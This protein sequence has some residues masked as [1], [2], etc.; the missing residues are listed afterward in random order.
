[1]KQLSLFLIYLILSFIAAGKSSMAS[2]RSFKVNLDSITLT[3]TCISDQIIHVQ[4]TPKKVVIK[5]YLVVLKQNELSP[6]SCSI[7]KDNNGL[8][9]TT[10]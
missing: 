1:M 5:E 10:K 4:A 3:V 7:R 9:L 8:N 2:S 6:V